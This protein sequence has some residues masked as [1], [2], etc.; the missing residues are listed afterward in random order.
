MQGMQGR[1]LGWEDLW[2]KEMATPPGFLS[3]KSHAQR[4]LVGHS[5][6]GRKESDMTLQQ[7]QLL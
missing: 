2:V 5:P 7:N 4:S 1:S 6:W 3:E